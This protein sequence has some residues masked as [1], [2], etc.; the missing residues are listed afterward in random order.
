MMVALLFFSFAAQDSPENYIT[1]LI[2][3]VS[4]HEPCS[5]FIL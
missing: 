2:Y 1:T 3:E 4:R 5:E